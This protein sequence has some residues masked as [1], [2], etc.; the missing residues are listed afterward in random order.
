MKWAEMEVLRATQGLYAPLYHE[1]A[2]A[3]TRLPGL[4]A[5]H[6]HGN[7]VSP[8]RISRFDD[9]N[10]ARPLLHTLS[11]EGLQDLVVALV[12]RARQCEP[13]LKGRGRG[14]WGRVTL[15][16]SRR[17][18]MRECC[19]SGAARQPCIPNQSFGS[20]WS[21]PPRTIG[22]KVSRPRLLPS[23]GRPGLPTLT[24]RQARHPPRC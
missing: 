13:V 12:W 10:R 2:G 6:A 14:H 24:P 19:P 9:C 4:V 5:G 7:K 8:P 15:S 21:V 16:R 18:G 20:T 22:R 3:I 1:Q 23:L 11:P 17:E